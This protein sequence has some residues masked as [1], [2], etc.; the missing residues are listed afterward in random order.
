MNPQIKVIEDEEILK[1]TLSGVDLS[2]A[3]AL[4]RIML[5]DIPT[6]VFRTETYNDNQC[7]IAVNTSRLHNEIIKQRL[8]C[9]PIH[10]T[11]HS[12][13]PGNYTLELDVT[14]EEDHIIFVTTEDFRIKNK[15]TG[16]FMT[17]EETVLI[18]PP[19]KKTGYFIDF[20]RLRPAIGDIQAE[21]IKLSCEFSI[22]SVEINSMF[23]VVSKCAYAFTVD[24]IAANK[25]WTETEN[26]MASEGMTEKE[27]EF[28]KK[29]FMLLDAQ[30]YYVKDSFD[31]VVRSVGVY[32]N[33]EIVKLACKIM[34][35]RLLNIVELIESDAM[36]IE[37]SETTMDNC[38][39]ITLENE[40][41]TIG[42][43]IEYY[44]YEN[45]FNG[46]KK[47]TFCGFKK[48]HPH[49][50]Y[51]MIRLAYEAPVDKHMIRS[52]LKEACVSI[53]EVFV[54]IHKMM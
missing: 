23:N 4:R 31:F 28:S 22:A 32:T 11:D 38:Y 25:A 36:M 14:N 6:V 39:D 44:L 21:Q 41:Y 12:I 24:P 46:K 48:T 1:F 29:N 53:Q 8:S 10:S 18:F 13:L 42:K 40:D 51:S 3:N 47:L 9:I 49:N 2:L 54:N 30:R 26:K 34:Q 33:I 50:S 35:R 52:D 15:T 5:N 17:K 20:I 27:I 45:L 7:K 19:N 16:N 37:L 43:P